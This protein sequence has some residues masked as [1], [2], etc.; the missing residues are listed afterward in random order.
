MLRY[1]SCSDCGIDFV[2]LDDMKHEH[3]GHSYVTLWYYPRGP[4]NRYERVY[5]AGMIGSV[6]LLLIFWAIYHLHLVI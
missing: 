3:F 1:C 2:I 6:G 4:L 5:L